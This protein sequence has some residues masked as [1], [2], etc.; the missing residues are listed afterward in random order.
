MTEDQVTELKRVMKNIR[1]VQK[2]VDRINSVF[3]PLT[4][5][6]GLLKANGVDVDDE[7]VGGVIIQDYL[8][9]APGNFDG[10]VKTTQTQK[11]SIMEMQTEQ[12]RTVK[13][14]LDKFFQEIRAF[15]GE[16]RKKAPFNFEGTVEE[17][18]EIMDRYAL[19]LEGLA[20]KAKE[21]NATEDLFEIGQT[22]YN[23]ITDTRN[24]LYHS[25]VDRTIDTTSS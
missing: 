20:K 12:Q 17:A 14:D 2:S 13:A 11:E 1:E 10:L 24:E 18:Y 3:Q 22:K 9:N 25:S 19:D 7:K 4:D 16:F 15:R 6:V 8:E 5:T 21:A 23:E